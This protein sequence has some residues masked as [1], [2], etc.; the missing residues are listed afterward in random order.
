LAV[1]MPTEE[2]T[3][4]HADACSQTGRERLKSAHTNEDG[5]IQAAAQN[6]HTSAHV[7]LHIRQCRSL[8]CPGSMWSSVHVQ[9]QRTTSTLDYLW[10]DTDIEAYTNTAVAPIQAVGGGGVLDAAGGHMQSL[11]ELLHSTAVC[12][13]QRVRSPRCICSL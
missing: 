7:M 3:C 6:A 2:C 5:I 12:G 1:I 11:V 10:H 13:R 8:T 9:L 4:A